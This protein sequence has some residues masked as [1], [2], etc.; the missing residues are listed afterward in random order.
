MTSNIDPTQI[1]PEFPVSGQNNSSQ[2]FRDNFQGTVQGLTAARDEITGLQRNATVKGTTSTTRVEN[3]DDFQNY[4]VGAELREVQLADWTQRLFNHGPQSGTVA[5]S[6]YEAPIHYVE[7]FPNVT[8]GLKQFPV[9]QYATMRVYVSVPSTATVVTF[10]DVSS[11]TNVTRLVNF[12]SV[13]GEMTFETSGVFGIEISSRTGVDFEFFDLDRR[14]I[15]ASVQT[16][17]AVGISGNFNDLNSIPTAS[18]SLKGIMQV[19]D[20][21]LVNAGVVSVD[22]ATIQV[23]VSTATTASV[24]VIQVGNGLTITPAGLLSANQYTLPTATTAT[25][26]GVIIGAGLAVDSTGTLSVVDGITGATGLIGATG[27]TGATG[28]QGPD[29]LGVGVYSNSSITIGTGAKVFVL[30]SLAV[31]SIGQRV[32]A[33]NYASGIPVNEWLEGQI[34]AYDTTGSTVTVYVDRTQGT[35]TTLTT[36]FV[37][38]AGEV[39][40][41]GPQGATGGPGA[42]GSGA[43]GATG[44]RGPLGIQGYQG[45]TGAGVQGTTGATGPQ[46]PIGGPGSTG[47][48]GPVGATGLIGSTGP[49]GETGDPGGATGPQG[50]T[51]A[52]GATGPAGPDGATGAGS[53]GATGL[54]GATGA[55]GPAGNVGATGA[56]AT[57]A[58][59]EA[60]PAGA[61]GLY[62]T[63]A[64][65]SG[66]NLVI[67]L[68]DSTEI[69]AGPVSGATGADGG[70]G[71][72]GADGGIGID[73]ATGA[74]GPQGAIG[75]TGSYGSTG[76]T[77]PQGEIG[78]TGA[79]S[80]VPGTTGATGPAGSTGPSGVGSTGADGATGATGVQGATGPAGATGAGATGATGNDGATGAQGA[81][82][83]YVTTATV[84]GTNLLITLN[85]S[86]EIN[87]GNIV[88]PTGATGAQGNQGNDGATGV[89]G[90]TGEGATGATGP[91]GATGTIGVDGATGATGPSGATGADSTVPGSTGV[92]GATGPI[93]P[94]GP[95]GATGATGATGE[96]GAT[97]VQGPQ[98]IDG[99]AAA[100]GATGATGLY[101][102]TASITGTELLLVL[103]D[104]SEINVGSVIGATGLTG[105]EGATGA[106][107]QGTTGAT[108]P[109]GA[110]GAL[111]TTGATG[112]QG[113]TGPT[114]DLGATGA[115]GQGATGAQGNPGAEGATGATGATGPAGAT[116]VG[117]TGATGPQGQYVTTASVTGTTLI[118]TLN[119]SSTVVVDGS[120]QGATGP[121][122]PNGGNGG[123]GATG[124]T[125]ADGATGPIG[126]TGVEGPVGPTGPALLAFSSST[127]TVSTGTKTFTDLYDVNGTPNVSGYT[128]GM[129]IRAG[130]IN[131]QPFSYMDG[132]V[133]SVNLATTSL[134]F[135]S[136]Y[137]QGTLGLSSSSW[138][139]SIAGENG[140]IGQPGLGYVLWAYD[141]PVSLATIGSDT[142]VQFAVESEEHAYTTGQ[143]IRA[144]VKERA[145]LSYLEGTLVARTGTDWTIL[146]DEYFLSPDE[147]IVTFSTWTFAVAGSRPTSTAT[148]LYLSGVTIATNTFSGTLVVAGGVG[149]GEN[150]FVKSL[151][152]VGNRAVYSSQEGEV[153]NSSSDAN[154]K[155]NVHPIDQGLTATLALNSIKFNWID[156]ERFGSQTEIGFLAQQVQQ[157]VPEVVGTNSDGTLSVDYPKLTAVLT[158]SIQELSAKVEEL[159]ARLSAA[160]L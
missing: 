70:I 32:R 132:Q 85:D 144:I 6:Y 33:K 88:G 61:T 87:A 148:Q 130:A 146:I 81:T 112:P 12:N 94:L 143:R 104:A 129:R 124:A 158:K 95:E 50:A 107:V 43:T 55:Q 152:G 22:T 48:T 73:G 123:T 145:F 89:Q 98:G 157:V 14:K 76:A 142:E 156:T 137:A 25:L 139:I 44:E 100:Q 65:I 97:G 96:T 59:G 45:A 46:G 72:T 17:S 5:L 141:N 3:A 159:E 138:A 79:D 57:G 115:T 66:T 127:N 109:T 40:S 15:D 125:G 118:L 71:A 62:V 54:P 29:G 30:E 31:W 102:T 28:V 147:D 121:I 9:D 113:A 84:T 134:I 26:G 120:I 140:L 119:D 4:M 53:T 2:G 117:A 128:A 149:I 41:T 52:A 114:G 7:A 82:G 126:A 80:I 90:A 150:L 13:S 37:N 27:P 67:I 75:A 108:G 105:S 49:Q 101:I 20:G 58:T 160:G 92:Q 47:S 154:L 10:S 135:I 16:V 23:A 74:T 83:L 38:V 63:S 69:D 21:L 153:T 64:T 19:G 36:W 35:A 111:G 122:G 151:Q 116:G 133:E 155:T 42:T 91:T 110:T 24:G 1:N 99:S 106:G 103:N 77:G 11:I 131:S 56:G 68:N 86:S 93:G 34:T 136:D 51:G 8:L 60:G 18:E 39:G 78:A